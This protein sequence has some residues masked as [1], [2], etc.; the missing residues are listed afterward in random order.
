MRNGEY[1]SLGLN[2][3]IV[4]RVEKFA[5][6][7][8]LVT[9]LDAFS[10]QDDFEL[11]SPQYSILCQNGYHELLSFFLSCFSCL[12]LLV[13]TICD[14]LVPQSPH[15]PRRCYCN[16]VS[17]GERESVTDA[18]LNFFA[19]PLV[20]GGVGCILAPTSCVEMTSREAA[21]Q[22]HF[23]NLCVLWR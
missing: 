12:C 4:E 8:G 18:A 21:G 14:V 15:F 10:L 20:N 5:S 11:Q 3:S 23:R 1:A 2:P 6:C 19:V 7:R 22:R 17:W 16:A 9:R 13:N